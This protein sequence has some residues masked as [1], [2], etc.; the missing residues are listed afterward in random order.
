MALMVSAAGLC[1]CF[2]IVAILLSIGTNACS[3]A[4]VAFVFIFQLFLGIGYLPV[5][6]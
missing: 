1:A 2:V 4:A 5:P 3:Y 6:W